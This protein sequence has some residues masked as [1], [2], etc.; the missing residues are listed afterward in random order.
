MDSGTA[1]SAA[2]G[3]EVGPG[4]ADPPDPRTAL[5]DA[6]RMTAVALEDA[7]I[8]FALVGGYA[9][10]ARGAPEPDHDADFAVAET[11][12]TRAQEALA[13]AGLDVREPAENWLF[14]AFHHDAMVDVLF[15]MVGEPIT[16]QMLDRSD[17]MEV[18]AVRMPVLDATDIISAK[19]RVLGEH[20]CDFTRMIA[21]VRALREQVDWHRVRRE[22]AETPYGRAFLLLVH[23]LGISPVGPE[24]R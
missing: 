16:G 24:P 18:L 1:T 9:A 13:A 6:L 11:D 5:Q 15:R 20:Y 21:M 12:V 8:P 14:K 10:W 17:V 2:V 19:M 3:A 23:E 7:G 4:A 22:T